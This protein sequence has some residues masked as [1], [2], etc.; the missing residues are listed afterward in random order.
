MKNI[1]NKYYLAFMAVVL[2]GNVYS[3]TI[4]SGSVMDADN[5]EAIPGVNVIIDGTNIGTVTDFDG[6]FSLNTSQDIPVTIVISYV[7]YSAQRVNVTSSNQVIN[8]SL[9]AGQN[10][11]EIVVSAS[12][13]AQ[14][15]LDAPASISVIN[16]REIEVSAATGSPFKLIENTVGIS[17]Q[18]Q[19][20]NT[21]NFEGRT[22]S[23]NFSTE[24]I[25][26]KDNRLLT[27]PAAGTLFS[28]QQGISSLD[29][30][31]VEVV[32]GPTGALYGPGAVSGVV[33]FITKS[34]I[35]YPGQKVSLWAGE[36]NTFGGE[37]RFAKRNDDQTFGYKFNFRYGSGDDWTV[38]NGEAAS[39]LGATFTTIYEPLVRNNVVAGQGG[40][41]KGPDEIDP[42]GDGNPLADSYDNYSFDTTFE[43][44]P[45]DNT[46]YKLEGGM[47][48]GASISY[49]NTGIVYND[50]LK[51]YFQ[52]SLRSGNF[53]LQAGHESVDSS[54][55]DYM[56]WN[57]SSGLRAYVDRTATD[58]QLQ[59]NFDLGNSQW[60]IGGDARFLGQD[61]K[62]TLYGR[63]EDNDDY[64][65]MGMY[66]NGDLSLGDKLSLN[67]S[68]RYDE[69]NVIDDGVVSPKFAFI[70]KINDT[71]SFRLS[72]TGAN[73]PTP[74]LQMFLDFPVRVIA[75]GQLDV[76]GTG[77]LQTQT[78]DSGIIDLA[79]DP[80][81]LPIDVPV[82]TPG[83][84]LNIA[85]LA[86]A[87]AS[88][89]GVYALA[90]QYGLD[91]AFLQGLLNPFF[92]SYQGPAGV[93]GSLVGVNPI[94]GESFTENRN[95]SKGDW[96]EVRS[97]EIGYK[98]II[99][100]KL[101]IGLDFYT[102]WRNGGIE[103]GQVGNVYALQNYEEIASALGAGVAADLLPL[104]GPQIA[105]FV[106]GAFAL[107][108]QG[109]IDTVLA[110]NPNSFSALG[111]EES[112]AAPQGDGIT[113]IAYGYRNFDAP[114]DHWGIDLAL[115]YYVNEGL[116]LFF[117]SSWVSQNEWIAGESN[118]DNLG[119]DTY[120]EKPKIQYNIGFNYFPS[121]S[122][123][124]MSAKFHH[125]DSFFSNNAISFGSTDEQNLVDINLGYKFSQKLRFDLSGT[126]IFNQEYQVYRNFPV[127][128]RRILGKITFD[129]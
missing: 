89:A 79:L 17:Y 75:P 113:H 78:F 99:G 16:T 50:G 76:W 116:N 105:Q 11:E 129:L 108:G 35:D 21:V 63:N 87:E 40:V 65:I 12:R 112:S 43:W 42:D 103:F 97:W 45:S 13:R 84:P 117:N 19:S 56:A 111:A 29:L 69:V 47:S 73:Q 49:N 54:D 55:D 72:Y 59:Y 118:D 1:F 62:N 83:F 38:P 127:I 114:R 28:A 71:N 74:A 37:A 95:T 27:T 104:Y 53:F 120:L 8:V 96:E 82:G 44:R 6:N 60:T 107:G 101:S 124:N 24:M 66:L 33:Q 20:I 90:P 36:L 41:V 106:G 64:N 68:A 81:G 18:Q 93:A 70:Y 125:K 80:L 57:Y 34:P 115:D 7:G 3:Q 126:N 98:G 52:G 121:A 2:F 32:R 22:G 91:P 26:L 110:G 86:A 5:M 94:T 51:Q 122:K 77:Q 46:T 102:L 39:A 10:L 23:S 30:E 92:A 67:V 85:Y 109:L 14:K 9:T 88:I 48:R 4:I 123:F 58:F 61:T 15:T 100:N 25:V 128:G 119:S 31:R